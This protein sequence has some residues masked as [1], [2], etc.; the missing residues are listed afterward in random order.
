MLPEAPC[1]PRPHASRGGTPMKFKSI[2]SRV[3]LLLAAS[4]LLLG[5]P[6]AANASVSSAS[7]NTGWIRMAH[8]SPQMPAV[9]VYLYSFGGSGR[10]IVLHHVSYRTVS[11]Y[12]QVGA[13]DYIVAMGSP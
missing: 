9:D 7:P 2:I 10:H 11:P 3:A 1:F 4:A 5:V 8:L 12:E 13:G 6:A